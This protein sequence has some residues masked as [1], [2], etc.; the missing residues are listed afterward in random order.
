MVEAP[1]EAPGRLELVRAFVNTRSVDGGTDAIAAPAALG[2][3]LAQRGLVAKRARGTAADHRRALALRE[4]LRALLLENNGG[5]PAPDAA[6]VLD[7]AARAAGLGV[8]FSGA[9]AALE[10]A[11]RGVPGALGRLLAAVAEAMAEGSWERLKACREGTCTWAFYDRSKN[12]SRTWCSMA[13][14]GN[15]AKVKAWRGRRER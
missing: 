3:W 10:P 11:A 2:A 4:A 13:V 12:R 5:G 14:C 7:A 15:R 1:I 8:R 6:G 9:G